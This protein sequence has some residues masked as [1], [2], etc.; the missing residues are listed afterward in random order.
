LVAAIMNAVVGSGIFG[1]PSAIAGF[2]GEWSPVAVLIAGCGI[3]VIVLCFAEVGSRFDAGG[4][5]YLY[6][7]SAFGPAVGFQVGWMHV[8]TRLLSAAAVVNVLVAYV[9]NLAP[10]VG[11][12]T[13]RAFTII[14][15]VTLVTIINVAGVKQAAWT[16]NLF[17]VAKLLPLAAVIILGMF[18][19]RAGVFATQTVAE[20]RWTDAVLLLVFAYGG[21]ESAIVAA[22]ETKDPK[23]DTAFALLI[24]MSAITIIYFLVQ[25]VVVGVLPNAASSTAPFADTMKVLMGAVGSTVAILAVAVSVFGWLMGFA[26]M[27]PRILFAMGERKEIP[28]VFARVHPRFR[29]PYVAIAVNSS[30]ALV[31]SLAGSFTQLA[32]SSA[33]TRLTIY[34]LCCGALLVLRKR[35]GPPEGF[36]VFAAPLVAAVAVLLCLWLL[37]TRS[38]AQSWFLLVIVGSG[39]VAWLAGRGNRAASTVVLSSKGTGSTPNNTLDR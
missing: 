34:A 29:T 18:Q 35:W 19:L 7:R 3:L 11:T 8:F 26:L 24:A 25:L 10:W 17:T 16:V 36:R 38:L 6:S 33:I 4:G 23:R 15:A 37:S 20:P 27:T 5:P 1:L 2:T 13:G 31:L 9:A 14:A 21:F 39:A 30:L 32:T 28:A 22:G 12:S